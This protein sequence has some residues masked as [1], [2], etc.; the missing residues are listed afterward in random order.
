MNYRAQL[1]KCVFVG[2]IA[3]CLAMQ[4]WRGIMLNSWNI[5][6]SSVQLRDL[7]HSEKVILDQNRKMANEIKTLRS[8][9][10]LVAASKGSQELNLVQ[11]PENEIIIKFSD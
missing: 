5:I 3:L 6:K 7:K 10:D 1:F 11:D 9:P 2:I 4:G 8:N